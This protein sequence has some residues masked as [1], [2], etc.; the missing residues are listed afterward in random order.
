MRPPYR[1][2]GAGNRNPVICGRK[3]CAHCGRWRPQ[4]DFVSLHNRPRGICQACL[5]IHQRQQYRQRTPEQIAARRE[6]ERIWREGE[7]RRLGVT[8]RSYRNRTT[9]V[10]RPEYVYLVAA[11]LVAELRWYG[12]NGDV[13]GEGYL[14]LARRSGVSARRIWGL[15]NGE[16]R[17]VRIDVADKLAVAL[18]LPLSTLYPEDR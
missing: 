11:P 1:R 6:Y 15:R 7:R 9:V 4:C 16:S 13:T 18:G 17:R 3:F 10:D 8:P 12:V 14:A 5:R 2:I